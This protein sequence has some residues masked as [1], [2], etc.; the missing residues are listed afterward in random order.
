MKETLSIIVPTEWKDITLKKW[1][2]LQKDL[3]DYKD[4]DD[5]QTQLLLWHLCGL[6]VDVVKR[7]PRTMYD[8]LKQKLNE[9][10]QPGELGL[11]PIVTI[12]GI[13]YGFE[14]NLS[15]MSYGTYADITQY[16]T[17]G[18]DKNWSKVMDILYRPIE[19]KM[20]ENYTIRPY[21]GKIDETKWE[22]TTMDI[23]FGA[24]FF[25]LH[26]SMDLYPVIL[27]SLTEMELPLSIKQTLVKSGK[28]M[29]QFSN[30]QKGTLK[31]LIQ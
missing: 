15:N 24:M 1:L 27:K 25:F 6:D 23:H 19:K 18:I 14:P 28:L 2:E 31:G 29:Q 8:S 13:E 4:D 20:G 22:N 12:D 5:A 9:F 3:E 11:Q 17:I 16:E 7:L 21:N 26:T 10:Q 30:W